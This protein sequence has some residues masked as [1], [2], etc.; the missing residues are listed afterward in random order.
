M[1]DHVAVVFANDAFYLAFAGKDMD[2]MEA[3]WAEQTPVTCIHPGWPPITGRDEVMASW[4]AILSGPMP[5]NISC[6]YPEAHVLGDIAYVICHEV[7]EQDFLIATNI[8]VHEG[9]TWRMVH[10][11]AG[12]APAP[13]DEEEEE[14]EQAPDLI[15]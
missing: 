5:P 12:P 3:V 11:Q 13:A 8:F 14:D 4:R 10:H 2:A 9:R 7:L 6:E 1:S 15:Q